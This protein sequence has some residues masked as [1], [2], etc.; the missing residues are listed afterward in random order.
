MR[1][2]N[3]LEQGGEDIELLRAG[4]VRIFNYLEQ[5]GETK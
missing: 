5:G 1:I 4:G 3:Y 2:V